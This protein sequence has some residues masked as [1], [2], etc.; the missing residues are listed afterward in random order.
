M[1]VIGFSIASFA[2]N[3]YMVILGYGVVAGE[4]MSL[5]ITNVIKIKIDLAR[6]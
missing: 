4:K 3:I 6:C 1:A 2:T 5:V